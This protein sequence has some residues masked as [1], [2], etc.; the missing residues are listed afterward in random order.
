[1]SSVYQNSGP[2]A[3]KGASPVVIG[4][5]ICGVIALI[6]VV[7]FVGFSMFV[8][9]KAKGLVAGAMQQP[10]QS[11]LFLK[12]IKVH[13]YAAAENLMS[14]AGRQALPEDQLKKLCEDTE[15]KL[16]PIQSWSTRPSSTTNSNSS[17]PNKTSLTMEWVYRVTYKNGRATATF[18]FTTKDPLNMSGMIDD[19]DLSSSDRKANSSGDDGS[20]TGSGS[21]GSGKSN[22]GATKKSDPSNDFNQ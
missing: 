6:C 3:R 20:D 15:Q 17:T 2:P 14:P 22:G 12:A 11:A 13:D 18:G 1:M 7:A 4:C 21:S 19:F 9:N 8:F 16:G 10:K 5:S